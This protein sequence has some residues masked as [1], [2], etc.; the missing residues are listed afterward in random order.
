MTHFRFEVDGDWTDYADCF[1]DVFAE[2][3]KEAFK[4]WNKLDGRKVIRYW[5]VNKL[6]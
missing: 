2:N 4:Q 1:H 6:S 5:V 3:I